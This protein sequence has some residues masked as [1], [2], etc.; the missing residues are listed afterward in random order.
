MKEVYIA[1]EI[2]IIL[3]GKETVIVTSG[4]VSVDGD[5]GGGPDDVWE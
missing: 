3:F 4:D 2:E 5:L 1:P